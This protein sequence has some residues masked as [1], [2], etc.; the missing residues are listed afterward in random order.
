[1][2][3]QPTSRRA[4]AWRGSWAEA[5]GWRSSLAAV[6]AQQHS[7]VRHLPTAKAAQR[8]ADEVPPQ[9]AAVPGMLQ[10]EKSKHVSKDNIMAMF[11]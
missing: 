3:V 8:A 10:P 2:A 9:A 5:E 4:G 6:E 1:M 11:N 7:R